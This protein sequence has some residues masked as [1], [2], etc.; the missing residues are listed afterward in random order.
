MPPRTYVN[1]LGLLLTNLYS[2][3][4]C[5]PP[6]YQKLS[7]LKTAAV[8]HDPDVAIL[9]GGITG[10]ASA[11]YLSETLPNAKITLYEGSARLGGWLHSTSVNVGNG[12]VV[13]EQGPRTLR[14]NTP[15][16]MVTLDLVRLA[17]Q[18]WNFNLLCLSD[19]TTP[20]TR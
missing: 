16:G 20:S 10:L 18:K 2:R 1:T 11:F 3:S 4:H 9:G 14:P 15:N 6:T 7:T 8:Y 17:L 13:F 19:S 12:T 5:L